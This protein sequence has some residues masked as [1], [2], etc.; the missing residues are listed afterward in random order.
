[1]KAIGQYFNVVLFLRLH[2]VVLFKSVD[3]TLVCDV[4]IEAIEQYF[5]VTLCELMNKGDLAF[6]SWMRS[7]SVLYVWPVRKLLISTWYFYSICLFYSFVQNEIWSLFTSDLRTRRK[8]SRESNNQSESPCN[9]NAD[10]S[11]VPLVLNWVCWL[12]FDVV[13]SDIPKHSI[14]NLS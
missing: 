4:Q 3:K 14:S 13:I 8:I 5:H 6:S 12:G 9:L 2:K 10:P 11:L 1:M 7:L